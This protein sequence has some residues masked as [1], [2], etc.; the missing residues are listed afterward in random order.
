MISLWLNILYSNSPDRL[1]P[2]D[3]EKLRYIVYNMLKFDYGRR[4]APPLF[5]NLSRE[6]EKNTRAYRRNNSAL[7]QMPRQSGKGK[8]TR[9]GCV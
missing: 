2:D 6:Q 5:C 7:L 3:W 1:S 4:Q 9:S 8:W